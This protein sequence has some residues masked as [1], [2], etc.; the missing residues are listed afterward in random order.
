MKS[1]SFAANVRYPQKICPYY[2][3][4]STVPTKLVLSHISN[5][6]L[7][8]NQ[9]IFLDADNKTEFHTKELY[10]LRLQVYSDVITR[11]NI[12]PHVFKNLYVV[13]QKITL[14]IVEYSKYETIMAFKW[15]S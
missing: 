8:K 12:N 4:N 5:S 3:M 7:F 14:L 1:L 13:F 6:F 15:K 10:Y 2:F 9:L 11:K